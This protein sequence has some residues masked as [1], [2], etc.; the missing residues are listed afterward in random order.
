MMIW[1]VTY[2]VYDVFLAFYLYFRYKTFN[3]MFFFCEAG[4]VNITL[5]KLKNKNKIKVKPLICSI[6]SIFF[7]NDCYIV[8]FLMS[9]T[10][11]RI[12][13]IFR[14]IWFLISMQIFNVIFLV[15]HFFHC[16]HWYDF[17]QVLFLW[18]LNDHCSGKIALSH[19]SH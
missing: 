6:D 15:N 10:C 3:F 14:L 8:I 12:L 7:N 19:W 9:S 2:N 11:K 16:E 5:K 13:T 17:S 18:W 1:E 4:R